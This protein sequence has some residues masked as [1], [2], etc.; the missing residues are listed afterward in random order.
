MRKYFHLT[1]EGET[2]LNIILLRTD[3]SIIKT[4]DI[5]FEMDGQLEINIQKIGK[6][7]KNEYALKD[8]KN[9]YQILYAQLNFGDLDSENTKIYIQKD[10][11]YLNYIE[12]SCISNCP[13]YEVTEAYKLENGKFKFSKRK[14]I[15][16][17]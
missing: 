8:I 12:G 1:M 10:T 15:E 6:A 11:L 9:I 3:N 17:K 4:H 16:L 2:N 13:S 14:E 5:C 7:N